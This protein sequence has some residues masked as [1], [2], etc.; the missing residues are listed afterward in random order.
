M[1]TKGNREIRPGIRTMIAET[2]VHKI[3]NNRG[4]TDTTTRGNG[5]IKLQGILAHKPRRT[6]VLLT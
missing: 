6:T 3:V 1:R 2:G 4:K 5:V